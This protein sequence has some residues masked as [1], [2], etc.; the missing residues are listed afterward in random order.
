MLREATDNLKNCTNKDVHEGPM[1]ANEEY[2][3]EGNSYMVI[4]VTLKNSDV[5]PKL[6][7]VKGELKITTHHTPTSKNSNGQAPQFISSFKQSPFIS[8]QNLLDLLK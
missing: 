2:Q 3:S 5:Y 1:M 8:S 6:H 4:P 7:A